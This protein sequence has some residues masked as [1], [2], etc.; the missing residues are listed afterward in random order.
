MVSCGEGEIPLR[1]H[2]LRRT[3]EDDTQRRHELNSRTLG[4]LYL[5]RPMIG[6]L[7]HRRPA[8]AG[9]EVTGWAGIS[10]LDRQLA[11]ALFSLVFVLLAAMFGPGAGP[12]RAAEP[13][14]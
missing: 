3:L 6:K 5:F 14:A 8:L 11:F 10:R 4:K 12:A 13:I 2:D 9:E 1:C 7:R